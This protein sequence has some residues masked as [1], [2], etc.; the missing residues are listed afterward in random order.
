M[1]EDLDRDA[2]V[3]LLEHVHNILF[4]F[5]EALLTSLGGEGGGGRE[6]ER[7]R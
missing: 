6:R 7:E 5:C 3:K 2:Q 1:H 4:G